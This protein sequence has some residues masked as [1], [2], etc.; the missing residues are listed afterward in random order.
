MFIAC[1]I[2]TS[3]GCEYLENLFFILPFETFAIWWGTFPMLNKKLK[4]VQTCVYIYDICMWLR[5]CAVLKPNADSE[6]TNDY[7][8][9]AWWWTYQLAPEF[10]FELSFEQTCSFVQHHRCQRK[11]RTSKE[12]DFI[13][14]IVIWRAPKTEDETVSAW[15]F[16]L[17]FS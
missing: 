9:T 17:G 2:D 12:P 7:S 6:G 14:A 4:K 11:K 1:E 16:C 3:R 8:R 15:S 10:C 13:Q 5:L